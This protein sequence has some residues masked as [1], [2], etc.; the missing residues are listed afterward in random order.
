MSATRACKKKTESTAAFSFFLDGKQHVGKFLH[1]C[2]DIMLN[3]YTN[4]YG[5]AGVA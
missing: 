5:K 2:A 3:R 4:I 1:R